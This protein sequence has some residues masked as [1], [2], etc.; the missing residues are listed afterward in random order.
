[1]GPEIEAIG[2]AATGG[3]AAR[4]VEP[5]AG[6]ADGHTH[7]GACLNCGCTLEGE[8]CHCCGQKAQVHR[9]L[10]AWWHDF[11]H[12][13]LHVDGK[14]WRTLPLLAW[15]PG[16]LTRRYARGERAKFISPLALFLFTVF[17]MFAVFSIAGPSLRSDVGV[18]GGLAEALKEEQEKLGELEGQR[19][20]ATGARA[21]DLDRQIRETRDDIAD[22]ER[23]RATGAT[24][25]P[26]EAESELEGQPMFEA[27]YRKAKQNPELLL[28]KLQANAYKF[29][30]A[31][32]PISIPFLWVLFVHRSRYRREFTAYDHLVFVT[33]SIAFMSLL[34][35]AVV[36]L[37]IAGIAAAVV[38]LAFMLIPPLHMY[39]Q[40]RGAYLLSRLS[41]AWRTVALTIFSAIALSLF[42][43][44]LLLVGVLG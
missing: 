35:I 26:F 12:S 40:L 30:W 18:S 23:L 13:V 42:A 15:K 14:F 31:L 44:M 38:T 11:L 32:I 29:S 3:L 37:G 9:T 7:E 34:L 2:D 28:Y 39:R 22:I 41:A 36:L 10:S 43:A 5:A 25:Q 24:S 20:R 16:E 19:A 8:Y 1:M 17:L 21:A 27:A 4:I 6:E 33:Y